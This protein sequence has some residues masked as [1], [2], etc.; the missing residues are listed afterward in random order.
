MMDGGFIE[1]PRTPRTQRK[2]EEERYPIKLYQ[3]PPRTSVFICVHLW[4]KT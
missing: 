2:K 1:P 4:L 3:K